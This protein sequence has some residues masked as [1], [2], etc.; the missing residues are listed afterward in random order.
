M[1]YKRIFISFLIAVIALFITYPLS[2]WILRLYH[3]AYRNAINYSVYAAQIVITLILCTFITAYLYKRIRMKEKKI[4][5]RILSA[6]GIVA[7]LIV[8]AIASLNMFIRGV[9]GH[10]P[11]HVV[12]KTEE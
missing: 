10:Q 12:A 3:L 5:V 2:K 6:V 4:C 11:E 1:P 9:F 7:V 8:V